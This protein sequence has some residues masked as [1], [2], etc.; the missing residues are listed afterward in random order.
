MGDP[1]E[2]KI[3]DIAV[4]LCRQLAVQLRHPVLIEPVDPRLKSVRPACSLLQDLIFAD[5]DDFA[6]AVLVVI[7]QVHCLDIPKSHI[8]ADIAAVHAGEP[9]QDI[10]ILDETEGDIRVLGSRLVGLISTQLHFPEILGLHLTVG[11]EQKPLF[12]PQPVRAEPVTVA[13]L[14]EDHFICGNMPSVRVLPVPAGPVMQPV[15]ISLLR[16]VQDFHLADNRFFI[17]PAQVVSVIVFQVYPVGLMAELVKRHPSLELQVIR[18]L[19]RAHPDQVLRLFF[20]GLFEISLYL[21]LGRFLEVNSCSGIENLLRVQLLRCFIYREKKSAVARLINK[22]LQALVFILRK[23]SGLGR[24]AALLSSRGDLGDRH[25][26]P[27]LSCSRCS[28]FLRRCRFR[29]LIFS[30]K[31]GAGDVCY[32]LQSLLL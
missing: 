18:D 10:P 31:Q 6:P 5:R 7:S 28:A 4:D 11:A 24:R 17:I 32:A 22:L 21:L 30:Q 12:H 20:S 2:R 16:S 25:R 1:G 27:A 26:R 13:V 19:L 3:R 29:G 15:E 14:L 8:L 9:A 23:V